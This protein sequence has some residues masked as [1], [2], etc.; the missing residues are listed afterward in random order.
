MEK[1]YQTVCHCY[2]ENFGGTRKKSI[3][4]KKI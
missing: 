3:K 4:Y 1:L 2:S